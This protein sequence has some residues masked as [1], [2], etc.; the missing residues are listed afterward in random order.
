MHLQFLTPLPARLP[1]PRRSSEARQSCADS[2]RRC[3]NLAVDMKSA[4]ALSEMRMRRRAAIASLPS[5]EIRRRYHA[6][7]KARH[8]R[9]W[10]RILKRIYVILSRH[11]AL[12]P[13]AIDEKRDSLDSARRCPPALAKRPIPPVRAPAALGAI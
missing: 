12:A 3:F 5:S 2:P 9:T 11:A 1:S 10:L 4:S 8:Q 6:W 13:H 7:V